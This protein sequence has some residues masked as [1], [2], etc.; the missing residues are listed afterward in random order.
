MIQS[1]F[2]RFLS[3][4]HSELKDATSIMTQNK[5]YNEQLITQGYSK[6]E[7]EILRKSFPTS[8]LQSHK[9]IK[10]LADNLLIGSSL[11][12]KNY[13]QKASIGS[14]ELVEIPWICIFDREITKSAKHGYYIVFLFRSDMQGFYMS[15]NQGWTQYKNKFGTKVGRLE[16][17]KTSDRLK[18]YLKGVEDFTF[19][20]INLLAKGNLGKGY[21]IGNIC[22]KYYSKDD[23][24]D[25]STFINDL[26]NLIGI[27]RELKGIVG[28]DI[29]DIDSYFDEEVFQ[30]E[31][32]SSLIPNLPEGKVELPSKKL[33]KSG[34]SWSRN[35][36]ISHFA[37]R[38]ANYMC[39]NSQ[40]HKTFKSKKSGYQFVEAHHLIPMEYQGEFDC[41]I[42]VPENI[43]SLCPNCHRAFHNSEDFLKKELLSKFLN[44]RKESLKDRGI[45]IELPKLLDYY[46]VEKTSGAQQMQAF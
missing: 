8:E 26:R 29:L 6:E 32:Q 37:L 27:Y 2:E 5:L 14:G 45:L 13:L 41:S 25:D 40:T 3:I 34:S 9:L 43:I 21:E 11:P 24:P 38:N 4:W 46:Q 17:S 44:Y 35:T 30:E 20:P 31:I 23:I 15:L 39:E 1:N 36:S 10:E 42:D 22:G 12:P 18:D 19:G 33:S 7:I 28:N 16:I